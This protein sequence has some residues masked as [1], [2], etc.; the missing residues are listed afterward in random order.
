MNTSHLLSLVLKI[1][2]SIHDVMHIPHFD[3]ELS[4]WAIYGITFT[5]CFLGALIPIFN[6]EALLIAA[7]FLLP[8]P[9]RVP[10]VLIAAFTQMT[11]KSLIYLS[12]KGMLHLPLG[13]YENRL[14]KVREKFK[15]WNKTPELF[16]FFSAGTSI[17]PFYFVTILFGMMK[18][19]IVRYFLSG[20]MGFAVRFGLVSFIPKV[21]ERFMG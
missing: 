8:A 1:Q 15:K 3:A 21:A 5:Y 12:A 2:L 10:L 20:F 18:F 11:G 13:K 14:Q 17:P 6:T 19:S 16:L 9:L 4:V 7:G